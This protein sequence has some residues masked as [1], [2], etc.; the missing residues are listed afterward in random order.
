VRRGLIKQK[1]D[2]DE[3]SEGGWAGCAY[4]EK[5]EVVRLIQPQIKA[6]G[7]SK[8]TKKTRAGTRKVDVV[9]SVGAAGVSLWKKPL[10]YSANPLLPEKGCEVDEGLRQEKATR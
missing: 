10:F 9:S 5:G 3:K 1:G 8:T 2:G 4:P 6:D 7:I